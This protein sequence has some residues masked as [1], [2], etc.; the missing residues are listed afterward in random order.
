MYTFGQP[1]AGTKE[2]QLEF[3][4]LFENAYIIQRHLDPV[5]LVPTFSGHIVGG[6]VHSGSL[7]FIDQMGQLYNDVHY[8][9]EDINRGMLGSVPKSGEVTLDDLRKIWTG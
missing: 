2:F 3:D 7:R 5:P 4:E 8:Q 1:R 6:Y 9:Y